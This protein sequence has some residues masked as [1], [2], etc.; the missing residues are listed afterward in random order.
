MANDTRQRILEA[1]SICIARD[2]VRGM[3]VQ[4]VC[5]Q[6]GISTGLVYYHF[7]DRDGLLAATLEYVNVDSVAQREESIAGGNESY[8]LLRE[9]LLAEIQDDEFVR[10]KSIVWNEI[11][12]IAVFEPPLAE[13]LAGS[14]AAWQLH[15]AELVSGHTGTEVGQCQETALLL[16]SLVEG[17]S[18]RWLSNQLDS[19]AARAALERG[20][21]AILPANA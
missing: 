5:K 11:K 14:T 18:S 20:M 10:A 19:A 8:G 4:D 17:L 2:G 15:V 6:A 12:A 16:T 13:H 3:R 1:C 7:T 9:L 21:E